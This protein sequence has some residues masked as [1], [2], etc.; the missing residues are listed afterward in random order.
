MAN[1]MELIGSTTVGSG[2]TSSINFTSIPGT[3]TDL[4][5]HLSFRGVVAGAWVDTLIKFNGSVSTF[6]NKYIYGNGANALTGTDAYAG[7]G[8]YVGGTTGGTST[9]N[10]F[11]NTIIYIPNYAGSGLKPYTVDS[12]AESNDATAYLHIIAGLWS[13]SSAITSI[14]LVTNNGTNFAEYSTAY[15]YGISKT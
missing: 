14:S 9:S 2:G 8:G 3:Y 10:T 7:S 11:S 5:L 1:T 6:E 12:A 4:S 13:T 15:L